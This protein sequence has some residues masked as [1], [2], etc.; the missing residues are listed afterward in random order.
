MSVQMLCPNL[1]CRKVLGVPEE[2]RGKTVK[3]QYCSTLFKVPE[4]KKGNVASTINNHS[5]KSGRRAS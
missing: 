2:V 3:C 4:S 1:Q 5:V